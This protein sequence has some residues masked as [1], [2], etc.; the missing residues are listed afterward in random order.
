MKS[1]GLPEWNRYFEPLYR[2][3]YLLYQNIHASE[4]MYVLYEKCWKD[5]L[6]AAWT[7]KELYG[8]KNSEEQ[9]RNILND[10][11]YPVWKAAKLQGFEVWE[12]EN[13]MG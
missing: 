12:N 6:L 8:Q 11:L 10:N 7:E 4:Y 2:N 9:V 1:D 13:S 3:Q 5:N